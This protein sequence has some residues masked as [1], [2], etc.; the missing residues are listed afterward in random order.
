MEFGD[1]V[2]G[3][4]GTLSTMNGLNQQE[5]AG[6][7]L[8]WARFVARTVRER[9][10]PLLIDAAANWADVYTATAQLVVEVAQASIPAA[11]QRIERQ[12][13]GV[14]LLQ[15]VCA[16]MLEG[17]ERE[18]CEMYMGQLPLMMQLLTPLPTAFGYEIGIRDPRSVYELHGDIDWLRRKSDMISDSCFAALQTMRA[19]VAMPDNAAQWHGVGVLRADEDATLIRAVCGTAGEA[20]IRPCPPLQHVQGL[21]RLVIVPATST[22]ERQALLGL[23]LARAVH[24][25]FAHAANMGPLQPPLPPPLTSIPLSALPAEAWMSSAA[26]EAGSSEDGSDAR[27]L[28]SS[29]SLSSSAGSSYGYPE[30]EMTSEE[31]ERACRMFSLL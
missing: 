2:A 21:T 9:I 30:D 4:L 24:E 28:A 26:S 3:V 23:R 6:Q 17:R 8:E 5:Q 12:M 25:I 20:S 16:A 11:R 22:V 15:Q 13:R 18:A 1:W 10:E 19:T 29:A 7:G 14:R 27:S 31:A